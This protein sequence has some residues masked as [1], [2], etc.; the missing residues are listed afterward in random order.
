MTVG[1]EETQGTPQS[2]WAR[3]VDDRGDLGSEMAMQLA[4][5]TAAVA[6]ALA[7]VA[8]D[9]ASVG[10]GFGTAVQTKLQSVSGANAGGGATPVC[11][12]ANGVPIDPKPQGC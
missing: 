8:V 7:I 6:I 12:D 11:N 2:V 5:L 1:N 3:L 9:W 10:T 4:I